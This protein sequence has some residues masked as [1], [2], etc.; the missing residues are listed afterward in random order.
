MGII[1]AFKAAYRHQYAEYMLERFNEF[2][3]TP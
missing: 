1:K 2:G 3:E